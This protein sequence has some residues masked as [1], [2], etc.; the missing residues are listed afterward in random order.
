MCVT[1]FLYVYTNRSY[2]I[3]CLISTLMEHFPLR[4]YCLHDLTYVTFDLISYE[5]LLLLTLLQPYRPPCYSSTMPSLFLSLG[6]HTYYSL[7]LEHSSSD[8]L[9]DGPLA[10][11]GSL[12]FKEAFLTTL[13]FSSPSLCIFFL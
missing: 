4:L 3:C 8:F 7:C 11:L 9:M 1:Q 10:S 2:Y 13:P 6:L 5:L 12:F